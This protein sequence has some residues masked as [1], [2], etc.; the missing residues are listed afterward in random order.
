MQGAQFSE[1]VST[2]LF[3]PESCSL[4]DGG[5]DGHALM[6]GGDTGLSQ[7]SEEFCLLV[8]SYASTLKIKATSYTETC[9]YRQKIQ[10]QT[11]VPY[12]CHI[13]FFFYILKNITKA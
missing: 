11:R 3:A 4:Q 9:C 6:S 13:R 5:S 2:C 10:S 1:D 12:D 8:A 7:S